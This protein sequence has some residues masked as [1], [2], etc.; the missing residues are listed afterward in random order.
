MERIP[1][2]QLIAYLLSALLGAYIMCIVIWNIPQQVQ[3]E[4][5]IAEI[6]EIVLHERQLPVALDEYTQE[7]CRLY[8][9]D[10]ELVYAIMYTK[11][12]DPANNDVGDDGITRYGLMSIHPDLIGKSK[13]QFGFGLDVVESAYSN[14]MYGVSRLKWA[15]DGNASI[16]GALMAYYYTKPAALEMWKQGIKTTDWVESVKGEL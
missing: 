12:F 14:V 10:P 5:Q 8:D 6:P 2:T 9:V 15:V 13:E 16:E 11:G 4:R 1:I 3:H 7:V